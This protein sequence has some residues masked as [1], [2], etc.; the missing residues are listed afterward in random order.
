MKIPLK[1]RMKNYEFEFSDQLPSR[2]PVVI[3][4]D[5]KK[6]STFT[7]NLKKPWDERFYF[8]MRDT[9]IALA[10]EISGAVFVYHHSDEISIILLN[11]KEY[12]T[13]PWF[14]NKINKI[15]SLSSSIA[16]FHMLKAI[17]EYEIIEL[18]GGNGPFFD[19]RAFTLPDF[20][21]VCNYVVYRQQDCE[22]NAISSWCR[23]IWSTDNHY[24]FKSLEK[25]Y[26]SKQIELIRKKFDLD[27]EVEV[28]K[29]PHVWGEFIIKEK[30]DG[31]NDSV[32]KN[33][34]LVKI[35]RI[36]EKQKKSFLIF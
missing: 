20:I 18:N 32:R 5:G 12:R 6:F 25:K 34:L 16:S 21:E 1:E 27:F 11:D 10:E 22:R 19:A 2:L 35:H 13:E 33:G 8:A 23:K 29:T 14:G 24:S 31:P 36:L 28:P 30:F 17:Q 15:V 26:G 7:R 4:I 9:A 3:R